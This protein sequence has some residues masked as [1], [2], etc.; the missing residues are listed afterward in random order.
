[1]SEAEARRWCAC[2]GASAALGA[3]FP[4]AHHGR[5]M[6]TVRVVGFAPQTAERL[7]HAVDQLDANL[8]HCLAWGDHGLA[9]ATAARLRGAREHFLSRTD[10]RPHAA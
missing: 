2:L 4:Y 6:Y 8:A 3:V 1:M 10:E 5:T 7:E 9:A